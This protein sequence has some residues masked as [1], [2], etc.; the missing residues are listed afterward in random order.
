MATQVPVK[1]QQEAPEQGLRTP[2]SMLT[3]MERWAEEL[4]PWKMHR[5]FPIESEFWRTS[6][7]QIDV[8]ERDGEIEV[9]AA[10]P[11]F[12]KDDLD[13]SATDSTVTIRGAKKV[14]SEKK[15]GEYYRREIRAED[16]LRTIRLP[17]P[18]D[19]AK[20]KA[21]IKDG[22]LELVLPKKEKTERHKLKIENA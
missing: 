13:V 10:V 6:L 21:V 1:R 22:V 18:V 20:A 17:A 5:P 9:H 2:A 4:F 3:E 16:F 19:D 11:G 12:S 15:E 8:I 14:E 7:P